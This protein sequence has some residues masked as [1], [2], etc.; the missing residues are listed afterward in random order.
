M[1]DLENVYVDAKDDGDVL[2]PFNRWVEH[3]NH[4]F[5][6]RMDWSVAD[7]YSEANHVPVVN[8]IGKT[9]KT[10]RPGKK[11]KFKV[12]AKDPDGDE[13]AFKWWQYKDAGTYKGEVEINNTSTNEIDFTVPEGNKEGTIHIILEVSDNGKPELV[14]YKRIIVTV[15]S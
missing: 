8:L 9:D 1:D 12:R 13:V 3:A 10:I 14:S 7:E 5:E 15:K 11:V 6:A 2:K 4:D